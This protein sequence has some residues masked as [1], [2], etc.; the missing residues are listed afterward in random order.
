MLM[1]VLFLSILLCTVAYA[2]KAQ[3]F[4]LHDGD[5]IVFY[6]DNISEVQFYDD[7]AEPRLYTTFVEAYAVTRFPSEHFTFINS[8]WSGETVAGGLGGTIDLRLRRDVISRRPSVITIMLGM[9]DADGRAYN[10][11]LFRQYVAG[12][13]HMVNSITRELPKARIILLRPSPYDDVTRPL[14]FAGGYNSVLIRYGDFVSEL[15]KREHHT[16]ADLNAPLIA[17]LKKAQK[18]NPALA[19]SIVPDRTHPGP[20]GQLILAGALL[21][22]WHA[23]S[24]VSSVRLAVSKKRF[25][26]IENTSVTNAQFAHTISWT[27]LDRA[28]PFPIDQDDPILALVL[29][30]SDFVDALD[31]EKLQVAE[32]PKSAYRL[33]I[34]GQ[35]IGRFTR[36]Q[37]SEG[38]NLALFNTPMKQQADRVYDLTRERNDVHFGRWRQVQLTQGV[39]YKQSAGKDLLNT[40]AAYVTILPED[41]ETASQKQRA[42]QALDELD[43]ELA[44]LQHSAAQPKPHSYRLIPE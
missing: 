41:S 12:Y 17:V 35:P 27:Q 8:A 10:S 18:L 36:S 37:L 6:G 43:Q 19:Q 33:E 20:A 22:A 25:T 30:C 5:R 29:Q 3:P 13:K 39:A 32:L 23:P 26:D 21:K 1:I 2:Q 14:D 15:G 24:V 4:A 7:K 16:V 34:D 31:Q 28:L 44:T 9:N 11:G 38:I 40:P 42:L